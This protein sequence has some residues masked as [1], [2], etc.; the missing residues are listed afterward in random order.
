[1]SDDRFEKG[2]G[3]RRA[4][5]GDAYVDRSLEAA[6]GD[7]FREDFQRLV[8]E[9]AWGAVWSRPG[10]DRRSR[11]IATCAMLAALN[12]PHELRL[13]LVGAFNNGCTLQELQELMLQIATYAG[14]PAALDA[15]RVLSEVAA[16]RAREGGAE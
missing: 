2:L 3:I 6:R 10:L 7:P 8:T 15:N 5:L 9:N 1:M 11:S 12:R 14:W 16:A 4:V 13:H